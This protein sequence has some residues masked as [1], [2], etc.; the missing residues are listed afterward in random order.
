MCLLSHNFALRVRG[1]ESG[2]DTP[3]PSPHVTPKN[4][5]D[6]YVE[7]CCATDVCVCVWEVWDGWVS[8]FTRYICLASGH[9]VG[10]FPG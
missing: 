2:G 4:W 1:R 5:P 10:Q 9:V 7:P 8:F 3:H 6:H